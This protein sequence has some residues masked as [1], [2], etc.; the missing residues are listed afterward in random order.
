MQKNFEFRH[1]GMSEFRNQFCFILF[2]TAKL[3][4]Y[5]QFGNFFQLKLFFE[6]FLGGLPPHQAS[7]WG[8]VTYKICRDVTSGRL[9]FF[10]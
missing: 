4:Q 6:W 2:S 7:F 5:F 9:H 10:P 3:V 8:E 1:W